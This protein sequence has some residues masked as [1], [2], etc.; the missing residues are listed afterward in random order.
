[1]RFSTAAAAAIAVALPMA[2]AQTFT[3]CDPTNTTCPADVGLPSSSYTADFTQGSSANASWSAA[4]YTNLDYG[5][6][7]AVFTIE[8]KGQAPTIATDFYIFF[9]RIDITMSKSLG[10][11]QHGCVVRH[12]CNVPRQRACSLATNPGQT[13]TNNLLEAAPGTG[14]VSSV[15]LESDD[16]DEIDWEFIGGDDGH[17]QSNFV[18]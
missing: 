6:D 14:I 7:G 12:L 15:V 13:N 10:Y 18:S 16:L 3:D 8:K 17:V 4:A 2:F 1:M 11:V 5:S 9:G